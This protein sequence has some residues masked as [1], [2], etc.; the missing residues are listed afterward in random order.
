[1]SGGE[2]KELC[3]TCG[4]IAQCKHAFGKFWPDR[5]RGGVGCG[6]RF[7]VVSETRRDEPEKREPWEFA[8]VTRG[9]SAG[10]LCTSKRNRMARQ[11]RML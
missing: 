3:A 4:V 8:H 7:P 5:S 1:M 10:L 6:Y 9:P 2:P 11:G